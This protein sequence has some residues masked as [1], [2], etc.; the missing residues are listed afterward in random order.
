MSNTTNQ[1]KGDRKWLILLLWEQQ[2]LISK[3]RDRLRLNKL[4][5]RIELDGVQFS[6]E[7]A[8]LYL[9]ENDNI[10][11]SKTKGIDI[12]NEIAEENAYHPVIQY[13]DTVAKEISPI[14]LNN[15][16]QGYFGTTDPLY[17][18]FLKRTLL[19]AVARVYQPGCKH[20]TT[21]VLQ[22]EQGVGKSTFFDVLGGD[23]F[24]D[25]MGVR[26]A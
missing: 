2:K 23:W 22:G 26:L 11:C 17:D 8:Y 10:D 16:S 25:S 12:F 20:D 7:F 6:I 14:S 3:N 15:L 4:K 24:D 13:L 19:A 9:A 1:E 21:L 5:Q 18:I